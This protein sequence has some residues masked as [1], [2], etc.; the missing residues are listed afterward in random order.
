MNMEL[1]AVTAIGV[2]ANTLIKKISNAIGSSFEP[3]QIKRV[4][5]A[6]AE[7]ARIEAQS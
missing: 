5:K 7:A 1:I 4:A 3:E 6:E 2:V